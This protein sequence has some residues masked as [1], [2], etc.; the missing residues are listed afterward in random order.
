MLVQEPLVLDETFSYVQQQWAPKFSEEV[1]V[2]VRAEM[3][4]RG[5]NL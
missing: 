3:K 1:M 5:H 2:R 4:K